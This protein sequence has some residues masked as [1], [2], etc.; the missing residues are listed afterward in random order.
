MSRHKDVQSELDEPSCELGVR[1]AHIEIGSSSFFAT[2]HIF[3]A[4]NPSYR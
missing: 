1:G 4:T 3:I 2:Q